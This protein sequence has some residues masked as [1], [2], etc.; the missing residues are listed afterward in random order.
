MK[1]VDVV[2]IQVLGL[3]VCSLNTNTRPMHAFI[4]HYTA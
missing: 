4:S 3:N 1:Q 2:E